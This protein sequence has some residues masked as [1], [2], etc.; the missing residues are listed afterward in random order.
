MKVICASIACC[1]HQRLVIEPLQC[2]EIMNALTAISIAIALALQLML[3]PGVAAF[4]Q[5]S[6]QVLLQKFSDIKWNRIVP[7]LGDKSPEIAFLH[8]DPQTKATQ[9]MI[10]VPSNFHVP[11]HWHSANETH[12]VVSGTFIL[13]HEG[14]RAE[15]GPGSFNYIPKRMIH[16]AWTKPDEGAVLFITV[17]SAWDINWVDGPPTAQK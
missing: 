16:Q 11:R 12:T 4:A 3:P 8:V 9:L 14:Q 13:D 2:E 17:D 10:R 1:C 7:E 6:D 5:S 15:L